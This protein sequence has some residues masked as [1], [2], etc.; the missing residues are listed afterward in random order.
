MDCSVAAALSVDRVACLCVF[1]RG[2]AGGQSVGPDRR[3]AECV[4][5][6]G[7]SVEALRTPSPLPSVASYCV[8]SEVNIYYLNGDRALSV[9]LIGDRAVAFFSSL[10]WTSA[11][12]KFSL[13]ALVVVVV[14]G[15]SVDV[16]VDYF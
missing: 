3:R 16:R 14:V 8:P 2:R 15:S 13:P 9:P 5:P 10:R 1:L 6:G 7:R 11:N 4:A 12:E